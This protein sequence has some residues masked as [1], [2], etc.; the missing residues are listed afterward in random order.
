MY[1]TDI[2]GRE[3]KY[4]DTSLNILIVDDDYNSGNALKTMLENRGHNITIIDESMKCLNKCFTNNY[5]IIFMD[6]HIDGDMNGCEIIELIQNENSNIYMYTADN[7]HDIISK[8]KNNNINGAFI[9][10]ISPELVT[11]FISA[12]EIKKNNKYFSNLAMKNKNFIFFKKS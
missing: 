10:P 3:Q 5:D 4:I 1:K 11:K 7:S 9:K 8:I 6:Y 12:I 2:F